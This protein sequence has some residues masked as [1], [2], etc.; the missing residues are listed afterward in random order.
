MLGGEKSSKNENFYVL[1]LK[2]QNLDTPQAED[3]EVVKIVPKSKRFVRRERKVFG[4]EIRKRK[5]NKHD[6]LIP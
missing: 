1:A 2:S 6:E 5:I 4:K 3:L